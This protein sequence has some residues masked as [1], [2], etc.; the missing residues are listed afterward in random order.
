MGKQLEAAMNFESLALFKTI[1]VD[2]GYPKSFYDVMQYIFEYS[3]LLTTYDVS[4]IFNGIAQNEN[5]PKDTRQLV[6]RIC[7]KAD[8]HLVLKD[9]MEKFQSGVY[10]KRPS[11]N[12]NKIVICI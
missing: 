7:Q 1:K 8:V 6:E 9:D 4:L 10:G 2:K 12:K 5:V 3:Y 11:V